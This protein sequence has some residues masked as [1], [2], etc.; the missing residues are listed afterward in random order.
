[1]S[2]ETPGLETTEPEAFEDFVTE[3]RG[4]GFTPADDALC[5]W[6]GP[7]PAA[8]EELTDSREMTV[9]IREGW[10]YHPPA[11]EVRGLHGWHADHEHAC[12]W[13]EGDISY[14]WRT[15]DGILQRIDDWAA[16]RDSG[17]GLRGAALD[18]WAYFEAPLRGIVS[19]EMAELSSTYPPRPEQSGDFQ[20]TETEV[21]PGFF[22]AVAGKHR[23]ATRSGRWFA[24][25]AP[26][27]PPRSLEEV[28]Q[29]LS[30][31]H[32]RQLERELRP[33]AAGRPTWS[34]IAI[35]WDGPHGLD[36]LPI[37]LDR[38]SDGTISSGVLRPTPHSSDARLRRAGPDVDALAGKRVALFGLGS[39]GSQVTTTLASSGCGFLRLVDG[40]PLL[41]VNLVRHAAPG[42]FEGQS[43]A[44]AMKLLLE[45]RC[46]WIDCEAF[47][48]SPWAV[49]RLREHVGDVDLVIDATGNGAFATHLAKVCS[50]EGKGLVSVALY[51]G[52][53]VARVRRQL[54]D[55][56]PIGLRG[57]HWRYPVIPRGGEDEDVGLE[58]GCT[59]PVSNA[60]PGAVSAAALLAADTAIDVLADR[61][62]GP[63]E[64]V[65][66]LRPLAEPPFDKV[67]RVAQPGFPPGAY[68]TSEART[69][70]LKRA[71]LAYP[72]ETGG[73]LVGLTIEG[74]EPWVV[75]AVELESASPSPAAYRLPPGETQAAVDRLREADDRLGYLGEWHSHPNA[76]DR[77]TKDEWTMQSLAREPD[78]VGDSPLLIVARRKGGN[79]ELAGS[80][81]TSSAMR[82]I[83]L[84]AAG[85]L[86]A[87]A[88]PAEGDDS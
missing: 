74:G 52:G 72:N 15:L 78:L 20:L 79:Y 46:P 17:F 36:V 61:H 76:S 22:R 16:S 18:A 83:E 44:A 47:I 39:V 48:E 3:L 59:A 33:P 77:S 55:D 19:I 60:P 57:S 2:A 31:A 51:R 32:R 62:E 56:Y 43:K 28:V 86:P 81:V 73:V 14:Q 41:P 30:N 26:A 8:L 37:T 69:T 54:A 25:S 38:A 34:V 1:M 27:E 68:L 84:R 67:G 85:R 11:V 35:V 29:L 12:L 70:I 24:T 5:R 71:A 42:F 87:A 82:S 53:S 64:V 58:V 9:V 6:S 45:N 13:Q 50:E 75:E 65:E 23:D 21:A 88:P 66:V 7:L 80:R 10:P 4:A 63:D 40:D 49:G